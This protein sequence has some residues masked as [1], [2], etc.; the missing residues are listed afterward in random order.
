MVSVVKRDGGVEMGAIH[1]GGYGNY[2]RGV[3]CNRKAAQVMLIVHRQSV[4]PLCYVTL[5]Y[6]YIHT[7]IYRFHFDYKI[8]LAIEDR[9]L[10]IYYK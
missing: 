5:R 9:L 7:Y 3:F 4:L 10:H 1:G 6:K 2:S 8:R